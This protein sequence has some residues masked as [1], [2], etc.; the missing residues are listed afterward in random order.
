MSADISIKNS[1]IRAAAQKV[2]E[3]TVYPLL[4]CGASVHSPLLRD[5]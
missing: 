4:L 2:I 1:I 3:Y 5:S